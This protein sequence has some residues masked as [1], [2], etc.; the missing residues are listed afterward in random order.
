MQNLEL[1]LKNDIVLDDWNLNRVESIISNWE[2][3]SEYWRFF[4]TG[5]L[6]TNKNRLLKI[7]QKYNWYRKDKS[8]IEA[9]KQV[10]SLILR[11][12]S[13]RLSR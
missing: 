1:S 12:M 9:T 10:F 2:E 3:P 13:F 5:M 6:V 4:P 8:A 7:I 11:S